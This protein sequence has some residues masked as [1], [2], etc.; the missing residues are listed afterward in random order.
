M[1]FVLM[2]ASC[3]PVV[4]SSR[5]DHPPPPW[6]YPDRVEVVRYIY[7]PEYKIYYDLTT[8]T[9]LYFDNGAWIRVKRLP[10]RY[11]HIDLK[12]SRY[13]R[14]KNYTGDNIQQY[15]INRSNTRG[16]SNING[17]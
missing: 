17:T 2:L 13:T 7:F 15:H 16:R 14:I 10:R 9:Y 11:Q 5:P 6:F 8:Y 3:G 4:I 12:R 1:M